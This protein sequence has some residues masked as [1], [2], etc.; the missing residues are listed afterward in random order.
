MRKQ[1]RFA[2]GV[3]VLIAALAGSNAPPIGA[4]PQ[5]QSGVTTGNVLVSMSAF[6]AIATSILTDQELEAQ[7]TSGGAARV[8][9]FAG[10]QGEQAVLG[11]FDKLTTMLRRQGSVEVNIPTGNSLTAPDAPLP[12]GWSYAVQLEPKVAACCDGGDGQCAQQPAE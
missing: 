3:A 12:S 7:L 10:K 8:L 11:S 2:L 6:S 9:L 1:V 4:A 5:S